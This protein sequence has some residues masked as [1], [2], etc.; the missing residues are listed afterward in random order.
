MK[1]VIVY[2]FNNSFDVYDNK[3]NYVKGNFNSQAEA[4]IWCKKNNLY[5]VDVFFSV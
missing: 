3:G 5:L 4:I 2:E 1:K